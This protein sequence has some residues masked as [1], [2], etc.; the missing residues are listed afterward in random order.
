M[1]KLA[2]ICIH[3]QDL[4]ATES[5]YRLLGLERRFD[6]QNLQGELVAFYLA[7][8]NQTYIEVI[9]I[10]ESKTEGSIAH[11]AIEVDNVD[12][13]RASLV[14]NDIEVSDKELGGDDTWMVTC[15]DPNG[16]FIE[17][18]EYTERSMQLVGGVCQ[19]DYHP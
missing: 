18:H 14:Q 5:F 2:H 8:E 12:D 16:I 4:Q 17:L 13:V 3:T 7:F 9:K 15:R 19:V 11:F 10:S 6:F 1:T